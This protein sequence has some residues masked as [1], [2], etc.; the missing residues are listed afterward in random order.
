GDEVVQLYVADP[1]ASV[2]RPVKQLKGFKRLALEPGASKTVTFTLD[3]RHLAFYDRQMIYAVEPGQIE[4]MVGSSSEDIR[5]C[6]TLEITGQP[7]PVEQ[8][9]TTP[10][11]V[12]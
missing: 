4:I 3:L 1:V 7:T 9:F 2:T 11:T 6:E 10:V 5:L 12:A 8:V